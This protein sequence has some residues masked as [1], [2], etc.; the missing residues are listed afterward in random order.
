[1]KRK[2]TLLMI[3]LIA[4][5]CSAFT[6]QTPVDPAPQ[7]DENTQATADETPPAEKSID[8][9]SIVIGG[10]YLLGVIVLLPLVI[11]TNANEKIKPV[12]NSAPANLS[13]RERNERTE[14]LLVML[15]EKL[16][17]FLNE[18]GN[19]M[20][21]ITKG[22][23]AR[24]VKNS[25]DYINVHLIPTD[26]DLIQEVNEYTLLYNQT[27]D[28]KFT[29]SKYVLGAAIGIIV[30]MGLVDTHMLLSEFMMLHV[31]GIL[32]YFMSSRT[33]QYILEK[34]LER[35]GGSK[36]G[37]VGAVMAGLFAGFATKHYVSVNGGTYHRDYESEG[38]HTLVLLFVIIVVSMIVAFFVAFLGIL[39]FVLNYSTNFLL[40]INNEVKWYDKTFHHETDERLI[41]ATV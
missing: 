7:V 20:L 38:N 33:P 19:E 6:I 30:F 14:E 35:F 37:I 27:T 36:L 31:L 18:D 1:M 41:T 3:I 13:E 40:P 25:L 17:H 15:N 21:T 8:W 12:A 16:T 11:Y 2:F 34:R 22:S 10:S 39:N 32:F 24:M 9:F 4:M 29:G 23:Q 5:C 26:P 28:R